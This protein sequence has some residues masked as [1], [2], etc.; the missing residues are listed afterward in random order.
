MS[1]VLLLLLLTM[2]CP[3]VVHAQPNPWAFD[4]NINL[5]ADQAYVSKKLQQLKT[6]LPGLPT[7]AGIVEVTTGPVK[8]YFF[9]DV[10][11]MLNRAR[12]S[13]PAILPPVVRKPTICAEHA[14]FTKPDLLTSGSWLCKAS[15]AAVLA[16]FAEK[17]V[18]TCSYVEF[19]ESYVYDHSPIGSVDIPMVSNW[20][21]LISLIGE[22]LTYVD[23][24]EGLFP[25]DFMATMRNV[26]A[27]LRYDK[28]KA[29]IASQTK[30]YQDAIA[31]VQ[32]DITCYDQAK[33]S[34]FV[35]SVNAM[36]GELT[37]VDQ[38][39]EGIYQAGLTQAAADRKAVENQ[40]RI[41]VDLPFP[42]LTD[43]DRELL[44]FYVGAVTWR[45]RGSGLLN[46]PE[47]S[48]SSGLYRRMLYVWYPFK[49]I[50][51]LAGGTAD[52]KDVGF[53]IF[54]DEN[55]G[56]AEWFDMGN[57]PGS[58]DKYSDL[59]EMTNR[60]KRATATVAPTLKK[61]GFDIRPLVAGGLQMGLCYYYIWEELY[62]INNG[63]VT[64]FLLGADLDDKS[65]YPSHVMRFLECPFA[66][67]EP[68]T[69]AALALGLVRT[70]LWGK[71]G[72]TV[73]TPDCSNKP[74]AADDG[75]GTPCATGCVDADIPLGIDGGV[76]TTDGLVR[77]GASYLGST[78]SDA[79]GEPGDGCSCRVDG[80]GRETAG[81]LV[82]AL[83]I[84]LLLVFRPRVTRR[85][86]SRSAWRVSCRPRGRRPS[87]GTPRGSC[88]RPARRSKRGSCH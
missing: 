71:S 33:V 54:F 60:G 26:L 55:W 44:A 17:K 12:D 30:A 59:V 10:I 5:T 21:T 50:A 15:E 39:L 86:D 68:C 75:C 18:K 1:R 16:A 19:P 42:A 66:T 8:L 63:K 35:T 53:Q 69:G 36:I 37:A 73:C 83:V 67:G 56:Y 25:T 7:N 22:A 76:P 74:C 4:F 72:G 58:N 43:R 38:Q 34:A 3:A 88:G 31:K 65:K 61:R 87:T 29:Q 51:E 78:E 32:A 52:A 85:A 41:R 81:G 62:E 20:N 45:I 84:V 28:L 6:G 49:L 27:K 40:G 70:Y 64:G 57:E 48:K 77:D 9:E 14:K 24:P 13:G 80:P 23:Y 47:D 2:A 82:L 79:H 11:G 46:V